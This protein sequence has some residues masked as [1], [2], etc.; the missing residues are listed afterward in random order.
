MTPDELRKTRWWRACI[1]IAGQEPSEEIQALAS[2]RI[3]VRI[4]RESVWWY[5][6]VDKT[7]KRDSFDVF[8]CMD[9]NT[10][11]NFCREMGWRVKR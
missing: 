2:K 10:A 3:R 6:V 8:A 9:R 7:K 1:K 4:E 5:V 11:L